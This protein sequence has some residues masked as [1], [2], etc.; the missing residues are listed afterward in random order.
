[1]HLPHLS[2]RSA[3]ALWPGRAGVLAACAATKVGPLPVP[4]DHLP[5]AVQGPASTQPL[6]E[7]HLPGRGLQDVR[8]GLPSRP[9]V[10]GL[11]AGR[12]PVGK[13]LLWAPQLC[14]TVLRSLVSGKGHGGREQ[15]SSPPPRSF[16]AAVGGPGRTLMAHMDLAHVARLLPCLP[17][18]CTATLGI[19]LSVSRLAAS[20]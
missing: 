4:P 7:P 18:A 20:L 6:R 3:P 11:S 19:P 14:A 12:R 1:M 16:P 5:A 13:C 9:R 15:G 8:L 10:P 2:L 17:A